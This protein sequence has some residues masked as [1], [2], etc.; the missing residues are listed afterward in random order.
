MELEENRL[1]EHPN[2]YAIVLIPSG[3]LAPLLTE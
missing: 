1:M 3:S 2:A